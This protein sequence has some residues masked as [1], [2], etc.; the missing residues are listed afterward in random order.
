MMLSAENMKL[1]A[2][3]C[4]KLITSSYQLITRFSVENILL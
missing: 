3:K 4:Y 2:E 1:S